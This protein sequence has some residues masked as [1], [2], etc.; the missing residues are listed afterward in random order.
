MFG[1]L[2]YLVFATHIFCMYCLDNDCC[3]E[4]RRLRSPQHPH[5]FKSKKRVAVLMLLE[6]AQEVK[7]ATKAAG[8]KIDCDVGL[9][10]VK[11][12]D[13]TVELGDGSDLRDHVWLDKIANGVWVPPHPVLKSKVIRRLTQITPKSNLNKKYLMFINIYIYIQ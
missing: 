6:A 2:K 8:T 3:G 7:V 12:D 13:G 4:T 5:R 9:T 11:Q 1:D 10:I